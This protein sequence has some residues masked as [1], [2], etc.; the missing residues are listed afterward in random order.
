MSERQG[1]TAKFRQELDKHITRSDEPAPMSNRIS[2]AELDALDAL[3]RQATKRPWY[4]IE[5]DESFVVETEPTG[6]G[7]E[8]S[9]FWNPSPTKDVTV[10]HPFGNSRFVA[11]AR[12]AHPRLSATLREA[13]AALEHLDLRLRQVLAGTPVRDADEVLERAR[14]LLAGYGK[15]G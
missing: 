8:V 2:K 7:Y 6:G 9:T 3:E 15:E 11:A 13:M 14:A 12:N 10:E 4:V 1:D 5:Y